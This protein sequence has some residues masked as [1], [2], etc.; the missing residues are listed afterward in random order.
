MTNTQ[1]GIIGFL[2]DIF[3]L[4][5]E[6]QSYIPTIESAIRI[7]N[8]VDRNILQTP[9][10]RTILKEGDKLV[11]N[12]LI[13][14][15]S[16]PKIVT[17]FSREI[18]SKFNP[19]AMKSYVYT[20]SPKVI[21]YAN[22]SKEECQKFVK[23]LFKLGENKLIKRTVLTFFTDKKS[24]NNLNT[25]KKE[26][27]Q[28]L[29]FLTVGIIKSVRFFL[30]LTLIWTLVVEAWNVLVDYWRSQHIPLV[31]NFQLICHE[32][33]SKS[34][35]FIGENTSNNYV[36]KS[37]QRHSLNINE[38]TVETLAAVNIQIALWV[39][40]SIVLQTIK[41][42]IGVGFNIENEMTNQKFGLDEDDFI[43]FG[44]SAMINSLFF[45]II[46]MTWAQYKHYMSRHEK[47]MELVGKVIYILAC[48]FNSLAIFLTQMVFY[49][50]GVPYFTNILIIIMRFIVNFDEYDSLPD[51]PPFMVNILILLVVLL[52]LKFFSIMFAR[53]VQHLTENWILHK[54]HLHHIN[55]RN[56]SGYD[57][58]GINIALFVFM[59]L[60]SANNTHKHIG[61]RGSTDHAGFFYF[62]KD[63][64]SK[65]LYRLRFEVHIFCKVTMHMFYVT[66]S[67]VL[68]NTFH[69]VMTESTVNSSTYWLMFLEDKW[70]TW[71]GRSAQYKPLLLL[72][73]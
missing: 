62:S 57:M 66:T 61:S 19:D 64:L 24:G 2:A 39:Y 10:V 71:L 15:D 29:Y 17:E 40:M 70:V 41:R 49:V 16:F 6:A 33:D 45:G 35:L 47:D 14:A 54:S 30:I 11:V 52:P 13:S 58:P 25:L 8:Y 18:V 12:Q 21:E 44:S 20:P 42:D 37:A 43:H 32:H 3:G 53:W 67:F 72:L 1:S 50:V 28:R 48:A 63:P 9:L 36:V 4:G 73:V 31:T 60:P 46:S 65:K 7:L 23:R 56:R 5:N 55:K 69:I 22:Q 34:P 59:F 68:I 26:Q 51:T 27:S 38:A